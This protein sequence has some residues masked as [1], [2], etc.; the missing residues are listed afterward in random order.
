MSLSARSE[1]P[2]RMD[3]PELDGAVYARCLADLAS[4]NRVT[5]TH[6]ATL[7]WLAR[8]TAHLPD[9]AAFSVL[10][11]AYGQG[12]LLRAIRA[13]PSLKGLP[14]LMVTAEAKKENILAAAQAG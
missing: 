1:L 10:D 9:G 5:F 8:A 12:D 2:E 4:V 11:V 3:A 6:R 14:V 13:E 7:A